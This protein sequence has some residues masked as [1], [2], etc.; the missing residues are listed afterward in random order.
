MLFYLTLFLIFFYFK[1]AR[2][3]KKEERVDNKT[4]ISYFIVALSAIALYNWG[5]NHYSFLLIVIFSIIF[6]ILAALIVTAVQLGIFI[7][8]KPLIGISKLYKSM[9]YL[10]G[11]IAFFTILVYFNS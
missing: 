8:G 6:F 7:D 2:V 5:I 10:T 9:P 11:I 1:L 3:H 4:Y